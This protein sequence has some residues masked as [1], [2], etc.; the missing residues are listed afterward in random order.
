MIPFMQFLWSDFSSFSAESYCNKTDNKGPE[1]DKDKIL[2][3]KPLKTSNF[4]ITKPTTK[5]K[6]KN[7]LKKNPKP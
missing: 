2:N 4:I 5:A 7:R 3:L 6:K 1:T